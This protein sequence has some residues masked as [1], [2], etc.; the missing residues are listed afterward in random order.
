MGCKAR[1]AGPSSGTEHLRG[2]QGHGA[3]D[4]DEDNIRLGRL[5]VIVKGVRMV[6]LKGQ[7]FK[8]RNI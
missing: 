2:V 5:A 4:D 6:V 8:T 3:R 7:L 1:S